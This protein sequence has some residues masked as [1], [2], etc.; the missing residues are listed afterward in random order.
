MRN[1]WI[2]TDTASDDA[3]AILMA[4][5]EPSV[6]VVGI[7]T[8]AGNVSLDKVIRNCLISIEKANTYAPP[9]Y[10]GLARPLM[11]EPV[12]AEICHGLDGLSDIGYADP[13]LT[14]ESE[15]AIDA[16]LNAAKKYDGELELITLGPMSNAAAA[17]IKDPEAF[18]KLKSVALMGGQ[19]QM[20]GNW[21]VTAEFNIFCDPEAAEMVM[22]SGVPVYVAP[23]EIC[24]GDACIT[25]ADMEE[26]KA[27]SDVGRFAIECNTT[28]ISYGVRLG[29]GGSL[30][31]ADPVAMGV[32]LWH[33]IVTDEKRT[34]ICVETR[35]LYTRGTILYD[36][37]NHLKREPNGIVC[38]AIDAKKFKEKFKD[39]FKEK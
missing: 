20:P 18:G 35:G 37:L 34:H 29:L 36:Y 23:F 4:L 17:Y 1:I 31:L 27:L 25:P 9:V 14:I 5:R 6:R 24:C 26:I 2:D 8:V 33:D 32:F 28:L 38:R 15:N 12:T 19:L 22:H 21:T 10:K 30:G 16:L 11:C 13:T 7:S 3:V 39:I